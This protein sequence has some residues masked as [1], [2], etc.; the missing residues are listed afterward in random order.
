M[1]GNRFGDTLVITREQHRLETE[2]H[3]LLDG[4]PRRRF[5]HVGDHEHTASASAPGDRDSSLAFRSR[6]L[7]CCDQLTGYLVASLGQQMWSTEK[8]LHVVDDTLDPEARRIDEVTNCGQRAG[9][10]A[11]A[12]GDGTRD[13]MFGRVLDRSGYAHNMIRL[14]AVGYGYLRQSH[15]TGCHGAGLVEHHGVDLPGGLE[16]LG[17]LDQY[18][19]RGPAACPDHQRGRRRQP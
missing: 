8:H 3:Q 17:S 16:H 18:S 7:Q 13:R 19:H 14:F 6:P 15:L 4:L 9:A 11:C 2:V 12:V 10:L 5:H 1:C